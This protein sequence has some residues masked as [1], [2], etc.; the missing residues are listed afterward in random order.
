MVL[1]RWGAR[2][3]QWSPDRGPKWF[4]QYRSKWPLY[5][6]PASWKK[7]LKGTTLEPLSLG[8]YDFALREVCTIQG[9]SGRIWTL[10]ASRVPLHIVWKIPGVFFKPCRVAEAHLGSWSYT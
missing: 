3:F 5:E 7:D 4:P 10:R 1:A 2:V 8:I 9:L 6:A